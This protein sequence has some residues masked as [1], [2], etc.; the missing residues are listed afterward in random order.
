MRKLKDGKLYLILMIEKHSILSTDESW[1]DLFPS[2]NSQ[3][4]H[5]HC[6]NCYNVPCQRSKKKSP[7]ILVAAGMM[8]NGVTDLH[9]VLQDTTVNGQ[10]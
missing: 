1:V 5:V 10:C 8:A 2:I 4:D 6:K 9:V 3:N 7:K